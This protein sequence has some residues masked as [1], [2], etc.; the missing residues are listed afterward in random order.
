MMQNL[1]KLSVINF[2]PEKSE[3]V[4][5]VNIAFKFNRNYAVFVRI[6]ARFIQSNSV[7]NSRFWRFS[8]RTRIEF[9]CQIYRSSFQP[10][11]SIHM[12]LFKCYFGTTSYY[13]NPLGLSVNEGEL[14]QLH[15]KNQANEIIPYTDYH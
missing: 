7:Y 9:K 10:Q 11:I 4:G 2:S 8:S 1:R 6:S 15:N 13:R 5:L 12:D 14:T 3:W